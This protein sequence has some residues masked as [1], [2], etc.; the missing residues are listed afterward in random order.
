MR[1]GGIGSGAAAVAKPDLLELHCFLRG[2]GGELQ[3]IAP[4]RILAP[5]GSPATR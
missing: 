1:L 4:Y 2:S 5:S 3:K